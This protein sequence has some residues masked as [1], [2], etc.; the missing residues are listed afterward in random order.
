MYLSNAPSGAFFKILKIIR[1]KEVG[2]RL[3]DM[4][5]TE[6]T[7]GEV[8]RTGL[9]GGPL[10]VRIRGYDILI[11]RFEAAGIEVEPLNNWCVRDDSSRKPGR[12]RFAIPAD[13]GQFKAAPA[14]Q[15]NT[16]EASDPGTVKP[17]H[18]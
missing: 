10:Q 1:G 5:F 3:A 13:R 14:Q 6:N 4:G 8:I 15:I 17:T 7:Q 2:K 9:F 11:R 18:V 16:R 12:K